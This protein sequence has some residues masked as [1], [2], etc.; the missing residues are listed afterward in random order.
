MEML[1]LNGHTDQADTENFFGQPESLPSS[2]AELDLDEYRSG[3]SLDWRTSP[4]SQRRRKSR[5]ENEKRKSGFALMLRRILNGS[6]YWRATEF[7]FLLG[8]TGYRG[9]IS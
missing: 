1:K 2:P 8:T 7:A 5:C 6:G 9:G 4:H 3:Q